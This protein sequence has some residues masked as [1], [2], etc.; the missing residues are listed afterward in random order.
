M[1][2]VFNQTPGDP[3]PADA[4]Y[5]GANSLNAKMLV[6]LRVISYLLT[7]LTNGLLSKRD[8]DGPIREDDLDNVR[9]DPSSLG[10]RL[11]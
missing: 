9:A 2:Y 11:G 8:G 3:S 10:Q 6:E 5:G 7:V 4:G 1:V